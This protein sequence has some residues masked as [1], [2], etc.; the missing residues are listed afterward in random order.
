MTSTLD[1]SK[2]NST[3]IL[4]LYNDYATELG[5]PLVKRFSDRETAERRT[6]AIHA[7]VMA[8]RREATKKLDVKG[9]PRQARDAEKAKNHTNNYGMDGNMTIREAVADVMGVPLQERVKEALAASPKAG[10]VAPV[11]PTLPIASGDPAKDKEMPAVRRAMKPM[12]L[13]PKD[14]VYARRAGSK[15]AILID[16][17]SRPQGATFGELYDALA[18]TGKPWQGQTIRSGL[19]WDV[20]H[21][22]GYGVRSELLNG[23]DFALCGR[24]YEAKRLGVVYVGDGQVSNRSPG[25][26]YDPEMRSAV[27]HLTY[28]PGVSAPLPHTPSAAGKRAAAKAALDA[29]LTEARG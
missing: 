8:S 21:L 24:H 22:S 28:P 2:H 23:V 18:A 14:K 6:I 29:A 16:L 7:D 12:D 13:P 15:Q 25:P 9:D 26:A 10:D 1:L 19:A 11:K 17:L 4:I 27:Y 20:N 3:G 5:R